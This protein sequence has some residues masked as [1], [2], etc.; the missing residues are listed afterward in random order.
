LLLMPPS[1]GIENDQDSLTVALLMYV[2]AKHMCQVQSTVNQPIHNI[3][4]WWLTP[5]SGKT[6]LLYSSI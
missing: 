6:V 3:Y 1:Q 5:A 2:R 4:C